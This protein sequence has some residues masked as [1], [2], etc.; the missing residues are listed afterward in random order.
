MT[1]KLTRI[2]AIALRH[3]Y[4]VR[5][6]PARIFSLFIWVAL[7][8]VLWGFL[9]RY[10]NEVAAPGF[11]FV[12]AF[13][14]GILLWDF[15]TR[16]MQGVTMAFF[17]D[18]W[19][20]N[21][22]NLFASPLSAGEYI[23]GLILSS[24]LTSAIGLLVMLLLAQSVFGFSLLAYGPA[25]YPSLG[26]LFLFGI[27]IGIVGCAIVL[28]FGPSA[29]WFIWPLPAILAPFAG[30]FY[31]LSTLPSWMRA[32][33]WWLPPAH[34]F[35]YLRALA[36]HGSKD[37]NALVTAFALALL[38]LFLCARFFMRI[39]RYALKSGLIARYSAETVS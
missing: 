12:T 36:H 1:E 33:A 3:F 18:V 31:P 19:S 21:F 30:V 17:E 11:N 13:V 9:S 24:I 38:I 29:E 6:N 7:D 5:G 35:E 14:G 34:I 15:F 27:A 8:I 10:L 2:Y 16:V 4:L 32:L 37:P 25:L 39:H 23:S 28:R 26:I 20:R 22:L